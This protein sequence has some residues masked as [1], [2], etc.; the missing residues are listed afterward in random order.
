M[1]WIFLSPHLDDVALSCGGLVWEL[2]GGGDRVAV[3]TLF[4]GD[5]PDDRLSAFAGSLHDR[6]ALGRQAPALRRA[7][8]RKASEILRA[9]PRH[10]S[11][12]DCIYRRALADGRPLYDS[13]RRIFGP[14][15]EEESGLI[16]KLADLLA[17]ELPQSARLVAPL[18]IGGHVD[19]RITRA[20]AENLGRDLYYYADFPYVILKGDGETGG[21][22]PPATAR[23][24]SIQFEVSTEG[25]AAWQDAVAAYGSQIGTFWSGPDA[26]R[27]SLVDYHRQSEGARLWRTKLSRN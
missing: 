4:A 17:G 27:A 13:E 7:E 19:H 11:F 25:L 2:T 24:E 6:W 3:W 12:P 9:I 23:L 16:Q 21:L 1:D 14:V 15:A 10:F 18:T 8:D 22:S 26:M 20:A 5:P